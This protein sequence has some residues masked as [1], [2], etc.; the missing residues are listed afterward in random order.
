[1]KEPDYGL[2]APGVVRNL[3][4]FGL[5]GVAIGTASLLIPLGWLRVA[6]SVYGFWAGGCLLL[7]ALLMVLSSRVGKLRFRDRLLDGLG[8]AGG[9][10][11]LDVGCGRG[12][13]LVGAAHRLAK[14]KAV[15]LDL[16]STVDQSG[17]APEATLENAR[18]AGVAG[19]VELH[20]GDMTAMPFPDGSFDAVVSNLAVH[21]VPTAEGRRAA[22]A[23]V[24]R[25]TRP[26]GRVALAD[27]QATNSYAEALR[28]AGFV[29]VRRSAPTPWMFPLVRT[30]SGRK[31]LE[32]K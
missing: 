8:L 11:V 7:T 31:P 25:V 20:T 13:L 14:G 12:L 18:R 24:A 3:A 22:V 19:R 9:E 23:E 17:N 29:D 27:F 1:M 28:A 21:N 30:V 4:L 16:W 6:A 10:R 5:L 32:P 2:D 26:G 15:G